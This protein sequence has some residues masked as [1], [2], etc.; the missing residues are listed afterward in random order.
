M[1]PLYDVQQRL[2]DMDEHGIYSIARI[3]VFEDPLL[4]GARPDL[5]IQGFDDRRTVDDLER[6]GL[7]Q[8]AQS[9]GVAIQHRAGD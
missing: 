6:P 1:N 2:D 4:A 7:G 8:R 3:V 5:A 9:R